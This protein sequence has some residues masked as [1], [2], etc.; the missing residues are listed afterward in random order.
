MSTPQSTFDQEYARLNPEQKQA[1][2]TIEGP[3][4]V[5]AGAGTG[6]TQTIAIRI[7][8]ILQQTQTPPGAILC[9]TF[10]DTAAANMRE[11]LISIIGPKAYNVRI[12]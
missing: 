6:K 7:A 12:H 9:L 4:M 3:V 10:T 11:R 1:V 5:I 2:D 8:N